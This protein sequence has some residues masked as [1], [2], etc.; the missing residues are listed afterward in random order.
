[1]SDELPLPEAR[2]DGPSLA[3]RPSW[4]W[5]TVLG[6]YLGLVLIVALFSALTWYKYKLDLFLSLDNLRL[7]TLHAAVI[8]TV[9]LGMT[10][11]MISGGIDLSVGYAVSLVTVVTVLVYRQ[12]AACPLELIQGSASLWAIGAGLAS[13]GLVG[14]GNGL[15][16]TRLHVMPFVATLGMMGVARGLGQYL[17]GGTRVAF[18]DSVHPPAWVPYLSR[19]EPEPT[20]L[21][22]SPS[23]W[24][25]LALAV[26][27]AVFLRYTV[28]G[29]HCYAIGSNEATARL[30][31]IRV[32]RTKIILYSLAG[33]ATGWAG[34]IQTARSGAGSHD[35]T[36]GLELEVIAAVVIGGGSLTGGQGTVTG[37][38]IGAL[39]LAVLQNGCSL[40]RLSNEVRFVVIG[41]IV[42]AV[43]ALNQ[44]RER[45]QG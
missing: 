34:I 28:L 29:R 19:I 11:I 22:V 7:I 37:T 13:G 21:I 16:I 8:A 42:I 27:V 14:L 40:M 23:V 43:A 36:A 15:V 20:W 25:V 31:G 24:S 2:G 38:L 1:V 10:V 30:C 17:A 4:N 3:A 33:L 18:P 41:V 26:L 45:R 12:A 5:L 9:A 39:I 35:V 32:G 44:W 6:P